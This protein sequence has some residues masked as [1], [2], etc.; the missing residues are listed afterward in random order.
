MQKL[1]Q[2]ILKKI[3]N[4][5]LKPRARWQ[6][7]L[8]DTVLWI[9]AVVAVILAG[10]F[11]AGLI[12]DLIK[13]EWDIMHRYPGGKLGFIRQAISITWLI[14]I[15]AVVALAFVFFRKTKRGYR[16]GVFALAGII[17]TASLVLGASLI[18]TKIPEQMRD[19]RMQHL[20]ERFNEERW[21]NPK[22][23][24]LIGEIIEIEDKLFI[25]SALDQKVWEVGIEQAVIPP[26]LKLKV[27]ELVRVVGKQ[28]GEDTFQAEFVKPGIPP[29][30]LRKLKMQN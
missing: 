8:R 14:G 13:A 12:Q 18:P 15:V 2:S 22:E 21:L 4:S 16:Y 25:L 7:R 30:F 3:K 6:F 27:E 29:K 24:F 1:S 11:I 23:G 17:L 20:P 9:L 19:L 28:T 5:H 26:R 10:I